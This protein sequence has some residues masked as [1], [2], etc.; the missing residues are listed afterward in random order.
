KPS[1][2]V[3]LVVLQ[4]PAV[5]GKSAEEVDPVRKISPPDPIASPPT[6]SPEFPPMKVDHWTRPSESNLATKRSLLPDI[7]VWKAPGVVGKSDDEASPATT[8]PP[9]GAAAT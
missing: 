7:T 1:L 2:P 5:V 8:T 9:P 6:D 3:F 4:A